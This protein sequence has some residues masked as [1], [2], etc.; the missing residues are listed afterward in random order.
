ML[1]FSDFAWIVG[2]ECVMKCRGYYGQTLNWQFGKSRET[3]NL[4]KERILCGCTVIRI[5]MIRFSKS[6]I[7]AR[8]F[9]FCRLK[10]R[11][12]RTHVHLSSKM[13][14]LSDDNDVIK[15]TQ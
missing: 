12:R 9:A 15:S 10:G 14:T 5:N 1:I 13:S 4:R 2:S 7:P 6:K 8:V 11:K 3:E